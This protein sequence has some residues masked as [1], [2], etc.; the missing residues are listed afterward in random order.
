M[1]C[2]LYFIISQAA[3]TALV[4]ST[5]KISVEWSVKNCLPGDVV[6]LKARLTS[7]NVAGFDLKLPADDAV[8]WVTH[9]RGP[10]LYQA[11]VY[12]Q[13]DRFVGQPTRPGTISLQGLHALVRDGEKISDEPLSAPSLIVGSFGDVADD[14]TPEPLPKVAVTSARKGVWGILI[15]TTTLVLGALTFLLRRKPKQVIAEVESQS[16]LE[17]IE[18]ILKEKNPPMIRIERFLAERSAGLSV[19]LRKALEA[20]VYGKMADVGHLRGLLEKEV[21]R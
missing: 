8:E 3:L 10:L 21:A 19:E 17:E 15:A 1:R 20:A 2:L 11:G 7:K 4:F 6:T 14:F 16:I 13:E 5:P 18:E 12:T 9:E